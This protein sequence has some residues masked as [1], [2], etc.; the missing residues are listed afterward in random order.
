ML[1]GIVYGDADSFATQVMPESGVA[2]NVIEWDFACQTWSFFASGANLQELY[3][4]PRLMTPALWHTVGTAAKWAASNGA[5]LRDAHWIGGDPHVDQP[6][7]W[8][9]FDPATGEGY[10]C[11]RNPQ[12]R[13][14]GFAIDTV[15]HLEIPARFGPAFGCS[16]ELVWGLT[17]PDADA[18]A[19]AVQSELMRTECAGVGGK[20]CGWSLELAPHQVALFEIR[21]AV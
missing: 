7:G 12:T 6:Y 5:M 4:T 2:P 11:I 10:A 9:G 21:C 17:S 14:V 1:H 13:P 18:A 16:G 15:R 3:L 8:A 19:P 20:P